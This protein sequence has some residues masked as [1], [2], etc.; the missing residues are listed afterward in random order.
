[1]PSWCS[2]ASLP[3]WCWAASPMSGGPARKSL[4][5]GLSLE[6]ASKLAHA[7]FGDQPRAEA[8]VRLTIARAHADQQEWNKAAEEARHA[9]TLERSVQDAKDLPGSLWPMAKVAANALIEAGGMID[10]IALL[11]PLVKDW[12]L[13]PQRCRGGA[14]AAAG[15]VGGGAPAPQAV[16]PGPRGSPAACG[17]HTARL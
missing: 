2:S 7:T 13:L 9:M 17:C 10:A 3:A 6:E 16:A 12:K 4:P 8:K 11:E 1:M 15:P 5:T 14:A